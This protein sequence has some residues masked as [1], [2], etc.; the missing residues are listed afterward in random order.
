MCVH[1]SVPDV[2]VQGE[3]WPPEVGEHRVDV[4]FK[5]PAAFNGLPVL[6]CTVVSS[7]RINVRCRICAGDT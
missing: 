6:L 1:P 3:D 7:L 4:L 5:E 2:D